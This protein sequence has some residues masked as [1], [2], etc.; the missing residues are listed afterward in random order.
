VLRMEPAFATRVKETRAGQAVQRDLYVVLAVRPHDSS[1]GTLRFALRHSGQLSAGGLGTEFEI[2]HRR[3]GQPEDSEGT[4]SAGRYACA[5]GR[6][7]LNEK[8]RI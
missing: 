3:A 6:P 7:Y 2:R 8:G 1:S 5:D 4:Q